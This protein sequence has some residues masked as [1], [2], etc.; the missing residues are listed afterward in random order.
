M[1]GYL[2]NL[3]S[4]EALKLYTRNGIYSTKL[5]KPKKVWRTHHEA[6]FADYATMNKGD[7]IYFFIK[8][9][10]YGIG[11]L[12][13]IGNIDCKFCNFPQACLPINK[14]YSDLKKLLLWDEGEDSIDQRW[15]CTFKPE[16]Y[17]FKNGI[18]MDDVLSSNPSDFK[19]LRAFWK[20]SFIKF[21]DTENQ[22]FKDIIIRYNQNA[23]SKKQN[24]FPSNYQ[25]YHTKLLK[26]NNLVEY[27]LKI[28]HL[29]KSCSTD[30]SL[31]HEM[32]IEA[33]ILTQL[34]NN[35]VRTISTFGNWDYLS[36]QVI[37]SPFKP[38]D[39]MDK[40]DIL[41]YRYI[42]GFKPTTSKYLVIEIK[43]DKGTKDSV[44]QLLKYIDWVKDEYCFGNYNMIEAYLVAF[45]FDDD[46]SEYVKNN[47][48]RKYIIGR[49]PA[50]SL[51]WSNLKLVKY[52]FDSEINK[53][54][55]QTISQ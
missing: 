13:N 51:E 49:R 45:N 50:Q 6:T 52:V 46:L 33:G 15:L 34:S 10:I 29:L 18:D 2:F 8:R 20:V 40:I 37:A 4:L 25:N 44:D 1:A 30:K 24:I 17:F 23:F 12:V 38:I 43:K 11:M 19:M 42:T 41:G 9:K 32:A 14:K 5:S 21:D 48:N 26:K 54:K 16:P 35:D 22:A 31:K 27:S 28:G 53:L 55:F 39:Y 7:N 3:D 47:A 36:H